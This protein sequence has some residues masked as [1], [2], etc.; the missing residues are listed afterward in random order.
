MPP[1]STTISYLAYAGLVFI[2]QASAQPVAEIGLAKTEDFR[3]SAAQWKT[4]KG[5][6]LFDGQSFSD[7]SLGLTYAAGSF[8][9][10]PSGKYECFIYI[11]AQGSIGHIQLVN[12]EG[13]ELWTCSRAE[14]ISAAR[15]NIKRKNVVLVYALFSYDPPSRETFNLHSIAALP[16]D[17]D[18]ASSIGQCVEKLTQTRPIASLRQLRSLIKKCAADLDDR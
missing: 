3:L 4:S 9:E 17:K 11:K 15:F 2:A 5:P 14:A 18:A 1:I 7:K 6:S 10:G 13:G 16:G 12:S 8:I